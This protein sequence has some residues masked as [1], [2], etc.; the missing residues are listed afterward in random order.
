MRKIFVIV[1]II[2]SLVSQAQTGSY[3]FLN[4]RKRFTVKSWYITDIKND[5]V[6]WVSAGARYLPTAKAV[7]DFVTGRIALIPGGGGGSYTFRFDSSY[8]PIGG[9]RGANSF[10]FKSIRI[11]R[12]NITVNP[13]EF[14]DSALYWNIV[15]PDAIDTSGLSSS[16]TRLQRFLDSIVKRVSYSDTLNLLAPYVRTPGGTSG[17]IVRW[18]D[19]RT[20]GNSSILYDNGTNA[21]ATSTFLAPAMKSSLSPHYY[22]FRV[23]GNN[24]MGEVFSDGS[25]IQRLLLSNYH[26]IQS[27]NTPANGLFIGTFP[28]QSFMNFKVNGRISYDTIGDFGQ[29]HFFAGS[30]KFTDT[31]FG[32]TL[33]NLADSSDVVATTEWVKKQKYLKSASFTASDFN[34]VSDVIS[35]DYTNGQKANSSQPGFM[36]AAQ[37]ARLDSNQFV[38]PGEGIDTAWVVDTLVLKLKYDTCALASF[39]AGSAA[40][41]D[42]A[43]FSTS[44]MYGSF[45]NSGSDTLIITRMQIGLQ[46]TSPN[47]TL[48]VFWN[49][50]LNVSAGATKLVT[51]GSAAT[52]IYTGTSVTSFNNTKIPPGVWIWV[53]SSA[54]AVKPTY[55]TMTLIGYKKRVTP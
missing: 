26:Y 44:A 30:G 17:S 6:N 4:I 40:A 1:A 41:G 25:Y 5:T 23:D 20:I 12:N 24:G 19:S 48:D 7:Y 51:A 42:T 10:V 39:G 14:G 45:F 53:K 37:A 50:S 52:N 27:V 11:R 16:Y 29:R 33:S 8:T 32:L 47:I 43:A 13:V 15:V 46:G 9:V 21:G 18:I 3:D 28:S 35:I 38:R 2:A 54:V 36:T 22:S 55:M 34:S 31:L 49:D